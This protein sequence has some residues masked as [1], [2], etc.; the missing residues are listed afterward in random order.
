MGGAATSHE[1]FAELKETA[2]R[3]GATS[4]G[5]ASV[6]AMQA[7]GLECPAPELAHLP[8]AISVGYRLSDA[9]METLRDRPTKLYAHHYRTVNLQLD[10]IAL[11]LSMVIQD[12]GFDALPL[13]ASQIVDWEARRGQASHKW[14]AHFAGLGFLGRN[15]LLVNPEFG[16]RMRYVS[17]FTDAPLPT[18]SPREA[19]CGECTACVAA[20]PCD[21]V[22]A[23]RDD[24]DLERCT[25]QLRVFKT[26]GN[27]GHY[28]CGLCIK[29]CPGPERVQRRSLDQPNAD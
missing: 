13:A 29:A 7:A 24:F 17:V 3:L 15:S 1:L 26:K 8:R 4:F 16:T 2:R 18:G 12:R 6:E 14:I 25:E 10:R 19:D 21:A 11:E 28:I 27:V 20:C 23:S 5:V 22:G 9:V